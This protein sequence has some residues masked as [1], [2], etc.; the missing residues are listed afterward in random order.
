MRDLH[1]SLGLVQTL[2]PAVTSAT[3][4]GAPVDRQGYESVEHVVLV[5][6]SGDTLSGSVSI[7]LQ[8]DESEDGAV[9]APVVDDSHVLGASVDMT[10]AFALIDDVAEDGMAY[11]VGYVGDARYSRVQ[12]VLTGTHT[13]GTPLGAIALLGHGHVKPA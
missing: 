12:A 11:S 7:T 4:A 5:G 1:S 3:R 6:T 9:W 10:G 8:L 2:D 13:N